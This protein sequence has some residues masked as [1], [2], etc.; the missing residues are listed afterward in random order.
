MSGINVLGSN[1]GKYP[2][3]TDPVDELTKNLA[4]LVVIF[5]MPWSPVVHNSPRL[6]K[7]YT[8]ASIIHVG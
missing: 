7:Y 3:S 4:K 8:D 6:L 1:L 5:S 2:P